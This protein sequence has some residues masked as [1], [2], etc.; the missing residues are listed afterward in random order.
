MLNLRNLSAMVLSPKSP[1][2]EKYYPQSLPI[3][4]NEAEDNCNSDDES[5]L[6]QNK[7]I[8]DNSSE[9]LDKLSR[10]R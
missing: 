2:P 4:N 7:Q 5:L 8:C 3:T 6:D 9:L 1:Q 10:N